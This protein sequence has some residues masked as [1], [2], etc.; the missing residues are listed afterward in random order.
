MRRLPLSTCAAVLGLA[1]AAGLPAAA[2]DVLFEGTLSGVCTLGLSTPGT[3]GL[4]PEGRLSSAAGLPALLTVLSV[5][6][7]TLTFDPPVWVDT[8]PDYAAGTETFEVAYNGFPGVGITEQAYTTAPTSRSIAT[9]PLSLMA[10]NA[11]VANSL[12]FAAGD[13]RMKV[14]VTCS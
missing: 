13:Y 1:L 5:G 2:T 12:G 6:S 4:D 7:N 8:A 3:L 10:V 11:R 14:V 9:L